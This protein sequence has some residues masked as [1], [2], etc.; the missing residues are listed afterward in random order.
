MGAEVNALKI[1]RRTINAAVRIEG[2]GVISGRFFVDNNTEEA[3]LD[4]LLRALN[5]PKNRFLPFDDPVSGK[6]RFLSRAHIGMVW[7]TAS[8]EVGA[9]SIAASDCV[10]DATIDYGDGSITGDV[11]TGEMHP[12]RRRLVDVLNDERPFFILRSGDRLYLFNKS[13]VRTAAIGA[14]I[15]GGRAAN[16][17]VKTTEGAE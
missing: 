6:V 8:E 10:E 2:G 9:A 15:S 16:D 13:R 3:G 7:P 12:D 17:N 4:L 1:K 11:L 5:R 14:R